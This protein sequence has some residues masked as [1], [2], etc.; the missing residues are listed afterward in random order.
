[1]SP[2]WGFSSFLQA[3]GVG[4]LNSFFPGGGEFAHQKDCAGGGGGQAWNRLIHK[5]QEPISAKKFGRV[6]PTDI[7]F[8][9]ICS[10]TH[11]MVMNKS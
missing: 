6:S 11:D 1:M 9:Q 7:A 3:S 10:L 4:F 5:H 8:E 2:G